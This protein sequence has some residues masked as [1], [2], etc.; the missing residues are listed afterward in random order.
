MIF[1][2]DIAIPYIN[3]IQL[4]F[5]DQFTKKNWFA[6]LEG[7]LVNTNSQ[8]QSESVVFNDKEAIRLLSKELNIAGFA[9]ANNHIFDTG[10]I[11]ETISFLDD[12]NIP[13]CGIGKNNTESSYPLVLVEENRKIVILNFGWEVIH[14]KI[15]KK[16][17]YGVN[18]LAKDSTLKV[19]RNTRQKYQDAKI[20]VFMH[21]CYELE[22]HPQPRE[23]EL[24]KVLIDNGA[25][26]IIGSH[27]QRIG[28]FE[29]YDGNPMI[30]S[31]GN[32]MFKQNFYMNGRLHF[33]D[34]CN[35]ELTVEW[36]FN[37]N[38]LFFHFFQYNKDN[39]VI[40]F[41]GTEIINSIKLSDYDTFSH[42]TNNEYKVFYRKNHYH[43]GK[44]VPV[45]YWEDSECVVFVKN[46]WNKTRDLL[47]FFIARLKKYKVLSK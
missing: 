9:L 30:Y 24:S 32:W 27:P 46:L 45:Y 7:A 22:A 10:V 29:Y 21:W 8:L 16:N 3:A 42:L 4:N 2:G 36:N 13:H 37:T 39:S 43:R 35:K 34:F 19:L 17:S 33:P 44:G 14:Y 11:E 6:N 23:R 28:G 5:P 41:L 40:T 1:T 20:I 26:G 18:S 25:D 15:A 47:I 31:L 38:E 12:I